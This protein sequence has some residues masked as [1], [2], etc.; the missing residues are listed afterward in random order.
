MVAVARDRV[1]LDARRASRRNRRRCQSAARRFLGVCFWA[2]RVN[3]R[4]RPGTL[5][6]RGFQVG[7]ATM[8]FQEIAK[9]LVRQFLKIHHAIPSQQ[10]D[11]LPGAVIE[12]HALPRHQRACGQR[13]RR[14]GVATGLLTD[15]SPLCGSITSRFLASIGMIARSA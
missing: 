15:L 11:G 14:L 10:I 8:L 13:S 6:Q 7:W 3:C 12:L 5:A 2:K 1:A 4:A 9:R